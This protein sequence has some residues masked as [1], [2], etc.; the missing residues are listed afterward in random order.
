MYLIEYVYDFLTYIK[1]CRGISECYSVCGGNRHQ[2]CGGGFK[3]NIYKRKKG[4]GEQRPK[5]KMSLKDGFLA[6]VIHAEKISIK[7]TLKD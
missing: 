3:N 2:K 4:K 5:R 1:H 7:H 6:F